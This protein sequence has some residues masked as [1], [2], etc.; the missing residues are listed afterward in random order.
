MQFDI[1]RRPEREHKLSY[2]AVPAGRMLPEEVTN[3]DWQIHSR[4]VDLDESAPAFA[5]FGI[6]APGPQLQEKGY[7]ITS[8]AHQVE[9][10][11]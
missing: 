4:S 10:N 1:Y 6:D 8:L 2:L 9:A 7:A 5:E 3:V 11:D